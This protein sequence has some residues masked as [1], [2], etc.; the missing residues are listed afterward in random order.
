M[1]HIR[2]MMQA[3]A[4]L[5]EI[6]HRFS[7]L[8]EL[9]TA[10]SAILSATLTRIKE[11]FDVDKH[12][13]EGAQLKQESRKCL[14][15]L[16]TSSHLSFSSPNTQSMP[17]PACEA[18]MLLPIAMAIAL[19]NGQCRRR[20]ALRLAEAAASFLQER[21][22]D[23]AATLFTDLAF[24]SLRQAACSGAPCT[25]DSVQCCCKRMLGSTMVQ[26]DH[27]LLDQLLLPSN[28]GTTFCIAR[29]NA[30]RVGGRAVVMATDKLSS[31]ANAPS[32][33]ATCLEATLCFETVSAEDAA[34]DESAPGCYVYF[35]STHAGNDQGTARKVQ[36]G[37]AV[38]RLSASAIR[39]VQCA[40]KQWVLVSDDGVDSD[41][42][43]ELGLQ[44]DIATQAILGAGTSMLSVGRGD[45]VASARKKLEKWGY[46]PGAET[47]LCMAIIQFL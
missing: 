33:T 43:D 40:A 32:L 26:P 2:C 10:G 19:C 6:L 13:A 21:W 37:T 16:L 34:V 27:W 38:V 14:Q 35:A 17:P 5:R 15:Q 45:R 22:A 39:E 25:G 18:L 30:R 36:F 4:L 29:H 9:D 24:E 42:N 7:P 46:S 8:A 47:V 28:M 20:T 31:G 1:L 23:K 3:C 44:Q 41:D 12:S 11:R